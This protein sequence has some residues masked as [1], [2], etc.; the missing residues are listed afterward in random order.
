MTIASTR[1][2]QRPG[3]PFLYNPQVRKIGFQIL[4]GV[5]VGFL[6]WAASTNAIDRL[7]E[8]NTSS[9]FDFLWRTAGFDISQRPIE[10]TAKSSTNARAFVV[11]LLNTLIVG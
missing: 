1:D 4:L 9:G 11:G 8:Q 2:E 6:I 10:F 7:R 3:A 5:I